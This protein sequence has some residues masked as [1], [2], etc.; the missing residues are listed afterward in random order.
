MKEENPDHQTFTKRR[1][2][3][4]RA[5]YSDTET[6]VYTEEGGEEPTIADEVE[7]GRVEETDGHSKTWPDPV[8][9]EEVEER[10]GD[11]DWGE[12]EDVDRE[13]EAEEELERQRERDRIE[14]E[15]EREELEGERDIARERE[16]WERRRAEIERERTGGY[17]EETGQPYP[18]PP[19]YYLLKV[20][21]QS[22]FQNVLNTII[23][24]LC[25]FQLL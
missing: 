15:R 5:R 4:E 3:K 19:E 12:E 17:D 25:Q 2:R 23:Y 6:E 13:R 24:F 14:V 18:Y 10:S 20:R 7:Q 22:S 21:L 1:E 11:Y 8:Y 9:E 16:E